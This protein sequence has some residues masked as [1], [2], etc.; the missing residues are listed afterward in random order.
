MRRRQQVR[1]LFFARLYYYANMRVHFANEFR[2]IRLSVLIIQITAQVRRLRLR[3]PAP[4]YNE[5]LDINTTPTCWHVR[6]SATH[7]KA[8]AMPCAVFVCKKMPSPTWLS[9][10]A[11]A[12]LV[13]AVVGSAVVVWCTRLLSVVGSSVCCEEAA[14]AAVA[15]DAAA[16]TAEATVDVT[17][18]RTAAAME[19][20]FSGGAS[21]DMPLWRYGGTGRTVNRERKIY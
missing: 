12:I 15:A 11:M 14:A 21:E 20:A 9:G 18:S 17:V 13:C 6:N 7:T 4:V 3:P 8:L 16:V 2:L 1:S 10:S 5:I 19:E